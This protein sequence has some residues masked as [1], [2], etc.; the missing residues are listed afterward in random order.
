MVIVNE[1]LV[2]GQIEMYRRV[3]KTVQRGSHTPNSIPHIARHHVWLSQ[4]RN[5]GWYLLS[6]T[7]SSAQS[8]VSFPLWPFSVQG[9][10]PESHSRFSCLP[11][12]NRSVVSDSFETPWTVEHQAPLPMKF[13][14]QEYW[15]GLLFP[16]PGESSRPR[17]QTQVSCIAGGIFTRWWL[18][19]VPRLL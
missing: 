8:L 12:V 5:Q 18:L 11:S 2:S 13:P 3:T 10:P 15:G 17:D 19:E 6:K 14:R 4:L 16:S 9:S 1:L 7:S